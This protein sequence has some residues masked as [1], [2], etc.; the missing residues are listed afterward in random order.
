[1]EFRSALYLGLRHAAPAAGLGLGLGLGFG[2]GPDAGLEALPGWRALTLGMPAALQLPPGARQLA[3]ELA[4]LQGCEA[5]TLLPSTLHLFRDLFALLG[6][7]PMVLLADALAYP[8]ARWGAECALAQGALLRRFRHGDPDGL[9]R[10]VAGCQALGRH[11]VVLADGYTP[12]DARPQPLAAY[13]RIAQQAGGWLVLDDTQAL[14]V[15]G[16]EGGGS[17]RLHGLVG[18]GASRVLCGASLAKAFGAPLAVLAGPAAAIAEFDEGSAARVHS[19]PPSVAAIAAARA[20]LRINREQGDALRAALLRQVHVFRERIKAAGLPCQG[21]RFP[22]QV[23]PLGGMDARRAQS[24]ADTVR[25][26]LLQREHGLA[27]GFLLRA[28]H[29]ESE[30]ERVAALL[31][32]LIK[33]KS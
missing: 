19:S 24:I 32:R 21:G 15:L 28:D 12:G 13:A 20:A 29:G 22:V 14:G 26:V 9:A 3:A 16:P 1:M 11:P 8:I 33:E 18:A 17:L 10:L 30:V 25:A 23:V 5:A 4:Y 6:R 2:A 31:V 27:L 7:K